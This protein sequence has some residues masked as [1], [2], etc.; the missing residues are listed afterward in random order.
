MVVQEGK[1][2]GIPASVKEKSR[3][4]GYRKSDHKIK[5]SP[6]PAVRT[7]YYFNRRFVK[8]YR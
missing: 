3:R 2:L 8:H 7:G 6:I 1:K 5:I 4:C